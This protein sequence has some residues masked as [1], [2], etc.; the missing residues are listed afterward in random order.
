MK[1]YNSNEFFDF[2]VELFKNYDLY[3]N[4]APQ[5][6]KTPYVVAKFESTI[7]TYP[8]LDQPITVTVYEKEGKSIRNISNISDNILS[9]LNHQKYESDNQRYHFLLSLRQ[10]IPTDML[11]SKQAI[12]TQFNVRVYMKGS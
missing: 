1:T 10:T 12:E 2:M 11:I 6:A 4:K 7:D 3:R 5:N 8:T 9:T